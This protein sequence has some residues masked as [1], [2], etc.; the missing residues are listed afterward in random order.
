MM[1]SMKHTH[2]VV[3]KL[4]ITEADNPVSSGDYTTNRKDRK[5]EAEPRCL[6]E[7]VGPHLPC[8]G[9]LRGGWG[10]WGLRGWNK[11]LWE[12]IMSSAFYFPT[13]VVF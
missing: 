3:P 2:T 10:S 11:S 6:R 13:Y 12:A 4:V 7:G 1:P 8:A 5:P 9:S